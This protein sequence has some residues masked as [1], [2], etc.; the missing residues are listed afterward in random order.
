MFCPLVC[1]HE[2][3]SVVLSC[4]VSF[5]LTSYELSSKHLGNLTLSEST[6]MCGASAPQALC[7][8][9]VLDIY[10]CINCMR[11]I[12]FVTI[13]IYKMAYEFSVTCLCTNKILTKVTK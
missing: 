2:D 13:F 3:C 9:Y 6:R 12:I 10:F 5:T 8:P 11:A 7:V 1:V 4:D